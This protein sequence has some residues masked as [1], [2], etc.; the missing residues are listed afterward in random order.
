MTDS[1]RTV[2]EEMQTSKQYLIDMESQ[3]R[4][5]EAEL[6][7]LSGSHLEDR[8]AAY[9]NLTSRFERENGYAYQSEITPES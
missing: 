7:T 1:T 9:H 6:Q 5:I 3:I 2:Y 8:L 4:K